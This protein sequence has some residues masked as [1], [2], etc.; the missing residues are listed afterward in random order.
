MIDNGTQF[1]SARFRDW[2][3]DWGIK[4]CCSIPRY[5]QENGEA[6]STNKSIATLLKKRLEEHKRLWVDEL[7]KVLWAY[8]TT[9]KTVT[10]ETPF[11]LTYGSKAVL[12]I[13]VEAGSLRMMLSNEENEARRLFELKLLNKI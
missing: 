8:R 13:E 12:P 9:S 11:A 5:P 6:E 7:P 4:L 2:C 10:G 1:S 3:N